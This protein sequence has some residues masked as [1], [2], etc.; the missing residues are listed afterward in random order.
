MAQVD[1]SSEESLSEWPVTKIFV[2]Y[3]TVTKLNNCVLMIIMAG[4]TINGTRKFSDIDYMA[5]YMLPDTNWHSRICT[6]KD[7][8]TVS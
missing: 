8:N 4:H 1:Q 3:W 6:Y 2:S 5:T 7:Y